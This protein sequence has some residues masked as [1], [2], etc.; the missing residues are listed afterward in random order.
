[1][2]WGGLFG[3]LGCVVFILLVREKCGWGG[4]LWGG[5]GGV[6]ARGV[7]GA[8]VGGFGW[9]WWGVGVGGGDCYG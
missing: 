4:G 2:V 8:L 3:V 5:G 7:V 9:V 6:F 1:V